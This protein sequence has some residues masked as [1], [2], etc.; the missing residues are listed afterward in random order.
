M[1]QSLQNDKHKRFVSLSFH[2]VYGNPFWP[3]FALACLE[4]ASFL[5]QNNFGSKNDFL[6]KSHFSYE[7]KHG[8]TLPIFKDGDIEIISKYRPITN[9]TVT[10]SS[11]STIE[12]VIVSQP[13]SFPK[14]HSIIDQNQSAHR[15]LHSTETVFY[16]MTS[17]LLHRLNEKQPFLLISLELSAAFDTVDH[18]I[19]LDKLSNIGVEDKALTLKHFYFKGRAQCVMIYGL[20][21]DRKLVTKVAPE[22][23]M[24]EPLLSI[25]HLLPLHSLSNHCLINSYFHPEDISIFMRF[26]LRTT[27]VA[28]LL[29]LKRVIGKIS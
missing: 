3:S 5:L 2:G 17:V 22:G 29:L 12:N 19:L 20:F 7:L 27:S 18:K 4:A 6:K 1:S 23:S 10:K 25:L 14:V 9:E 13:Q 11:V 24:L 8:V 16:D 28:I 21:S 15:S 26:D